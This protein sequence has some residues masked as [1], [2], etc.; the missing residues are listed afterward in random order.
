MWLLSETYEKELTSETTSLKTPTD[1]KDLLVEIGPRLN[2]STA[3]STNAISILH[4]CGL[5]NIKRVERSIRYILHSDVTI[6]D[7]VK[8]K[9]I[10]KKKTQWI[11]YII[12]VSRLHFYSL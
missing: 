12:I 4:A 7:E 6:S 11:Y 5:R 10:G 1:N 2:F 9:F 3:W 8:A